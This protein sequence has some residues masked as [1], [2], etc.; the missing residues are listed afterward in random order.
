MPL[1]PFH[2][3]GPHSSFPISPQVNLTAN[4]VGD[5]GAA[6]VARLQAAPRLTSLALDLTLNRAIR[7]SGVG[8]FADFGFFCPISL[9]AL[10]LQLDWNN[11]RDSEAKA[12]PSPPPPSPRQ[13]TPPE[14]S[15][16]HTVPCTKLAV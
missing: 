12:C 11:L 4:G 9:R 2:T 15:V 5:Q 3:P 16:P 1:T 8:A 6:A 7:E 10:T 13:W 14:Y